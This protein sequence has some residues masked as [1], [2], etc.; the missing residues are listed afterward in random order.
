ML[1]SSTSSAAARRARRLSCR[2]LGP[3]GPLDA[4]VEDA[5]SEGLFI[6][7]AR[8]I[9]AGAPVVVRLDGSEEQPG[10]VAWSGRGPLEAAPA[11]GFAVRFTPPL[12]RPPL[13]GRDLHRAGATPLVLVSEDEIEEA[14]YAIAAER[15]GE[16]VQPAVG[17][18]MRLGT[19]RR[20]AGHWH[21][22]QLSERLLTFPSV[23]PALV[24]TVVEARLHGLLVLALVD[25]LLH[26]RD[27]RRFDA[28]LLRLEGDVPAA[29]DPVVD[30]AV[31]LWRRMWR[32]LEELPRFAELAPV[33]RHDWREVLGALRYARLTVEVPEL[34]TAAALEASEEQRLLVI[35]G[36]TIDLMASPHVQ[37]RDF[38]CHRRAAALCARLAWI[39]G[40]LTTWR[41]QLDEGPRVG[42]LLGRALEE[43]VLSPDDV[44]G[45]SAD[46]LAWLVRAS[47]IE[48]RLLIEWEERR[49]LLAALA[50]EWPAGRAVDLARRMQSVLVLQLAAARRA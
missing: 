45:A 23:E 13:G 21:A 19:R 32:R 39:G 26:A 17:R 8:P 16:L 4:V 42:G 29:R 10:L 2:V 5:S 12:P 15:L 7:T 20:G 38:G 24:E 31:D 37:R 18:V 43:R 30:G 41:R 28:L 47:G 35:A 27:R 1:A 46:T 11:P 33:L 14:G 40:A 3:G 34:R 9:A 22:A 48:R 44:A 36:A 50:A 6:P 25:E 49:A